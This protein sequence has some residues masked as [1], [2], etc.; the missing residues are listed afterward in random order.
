MTK[1]SIFWCNHTLYP[2]NA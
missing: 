2:K 1:P